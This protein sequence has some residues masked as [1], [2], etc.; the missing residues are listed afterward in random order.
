MGLCFILYGFVGRGCED[1]GNLLFWAP[2]EFYIAG[3][4]HFAMR[5]TASGSR[6]KGSRDDKAGWL[7]GAGLCKEYLPD[8]PPLRLC[9]EDPNLEWAF[10]KIRTLRPN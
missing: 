5:F 6:G 9:D 1:L 2:L 3:M 4:L 8:C 10:Q 7:E